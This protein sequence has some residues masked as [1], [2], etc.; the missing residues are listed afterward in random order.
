MPERKTSRRSFRAG[1]GEYA[2]E[3]GP[4][5]AVRDLRERFMRAA[6]EC[7]PM[8]ESELRR[9]YD[10]HLRG[11]SAWL[12]PAIGGNVGVPSDQAAALAEPLLRHWGEQFRLHDPWCLNWTWNTKLAVWWAKEQKLAAVLLGS[13]SGPMLPHAEVIRVEI[14]P[15]D[16]TESTRSTFEKQAREQFEGKLTGYCEELE[17]RARSAGFIRTKELRNADH[18]RWLAGYQV[19]RFSRNAIADAV[20]VRR[21]AIQYAINGLAKEIELSLRPPTTSRRVSSAEISA[22]LA[23]KSA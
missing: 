15:W 3:E 7:G 23:R 18:F 21:N 22:T 16:I 11:E 2:A 19:C 12:R 14:Q 4:F 20:G 1:G 8:L 17:E 6:F 13:W 5:S 10:A 9:L